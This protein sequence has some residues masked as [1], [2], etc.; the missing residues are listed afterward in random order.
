VPVSSPTTANMTRHRLSLSL[1]VALLCLF[2]CANSR[3]PSS[4]GIPAGWHS[5]A[6]GMKRFSFAYP[7]TWSSRYPVTTYR[8]A[9]D[10]NDP[11]Q[12]P[13]DLVEALV[14]PANQQPLGNLA[15]PTKPEPWFVEIYLDPFDNPRS[16]RDDLRRRASQGWGSFTEHAEVRSTHKGGVLRQT[17]SVIPPRGYSGP[18]WCGGCVNVAYYFDWGSD[19]FL[20]V[21]WL[22]SP[23]DIARWE[24]IATQIA[25]TLRD[26][27]IAN[28]N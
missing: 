25:G 17:L 7:G 9:I 6:D 16:L 22:G 24:K 18:Q 10:P 8:S 5:F 13:G 15:D 14:I 2:S 12:T 3:E 11:Q 19:G 28:T 20:Y 26:P 27:R 23:P 21:R 1:V 4:G